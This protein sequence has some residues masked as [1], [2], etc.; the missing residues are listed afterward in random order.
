MQDQQRE[1]E[2]KT[3]AEQPPATA[4]DQTSGEKPQTEQKPDG[5]AIEGAGDTDEVK[6]VQIEKDV[7]DRLIKTKV[8]KIWQKDTSAADVPEKKVQVDQATS[9]LYMNGIVFAKYLLTLKRIMVS[10]K[11]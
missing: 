3:S 9:C 11:A 4:A 8:L 5:S 1:Q 10:T 2:Q 6:C 7:W